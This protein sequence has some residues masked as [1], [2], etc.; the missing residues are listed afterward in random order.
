MKTKSDY[1]K[2]QVLQINAFSA[3]IRVAA[4][5]ILNL[6]HTETCLIDTPVFSVLAKAISRITEILEELEINLDLL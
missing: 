6:Y 1:E 2:L 5:T 4:V 3:K